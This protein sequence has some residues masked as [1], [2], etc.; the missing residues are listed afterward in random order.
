MR[1]KQ[2]IVLSKQKVTKGWQCAEPFD[3]YETNKLVS[4][5]KI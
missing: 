1:K 5:I 2:N 3:F 4:Y